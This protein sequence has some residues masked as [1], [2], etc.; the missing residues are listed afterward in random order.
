MLIQEGKKKKKKNSIDSLCKDIR[1]VHPGISLILWAGEAVREPAPVPAL[2]TY[3]MPCCS[4]S[5]RCGG[6]FKP[7]PCQKLPSFGGKQH[8]GNTP[9][10]DGEVDS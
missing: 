6:R 3:T 4:G 2:H 7:S 8:P 10:S 1:P 5:Q 9:R